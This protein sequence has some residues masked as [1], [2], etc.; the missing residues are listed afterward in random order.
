MKR[1][2]TILVGVFLAAPVY[3]A[4]N[5]HTLGTLSEIELALTAGKPVNVTVDLSLCAPGV[6]D[7]PA[8]K[9]QGGMRI[10]AYRITT[11]GTLAFA[12]QHFTIDRDGKPIT[13]FIRYQ[14]RS[15]GDA[16]FTMVTFNMPTYERKGTSLAYKCAIDHGLSF[17]TPQ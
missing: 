10:D 2:S 8:T 6:A 12:D 5:I 17:R 16:D 15:N 11:D 3:A 4:D 9:T 14:I 13:Q 1:I 7:T